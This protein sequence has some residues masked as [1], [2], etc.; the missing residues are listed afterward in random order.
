MKKKIPNAKHNDNNIKHKIP[1]CAYVSSRGLDEHQCVTYE[2]LT[3]V[4]YLLG[5]TESCQYFGIL[6]PRNTKIRFVYKCDCVALQCNK[7]VLVW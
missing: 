3:E 6:V 1:G 2:T 5:A 4:A 7:K